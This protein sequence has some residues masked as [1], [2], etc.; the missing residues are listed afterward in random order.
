MIEL[1]G[2]A[3]HMAAH[4]VICHPTQAN[5][6]HPELYNVHCCPKMGWVST[7][8]V[9]TVAEKEDYFIPDTYLSTFHPASHM[10]ARWMHWATRW[11][12]SAALIV[13]S[14]SA[15][16]QVVSAHI[17]QISPDNVHPVFLYLIRPGFLLWSVVSSHCIAL[18]R[19][20]GVLY[21]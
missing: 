10:I 11:R 12:H 5:T 8:L 3:C 6:P 4:N 7:P 17:L 19:Y 13:A 16:S 21:S 14:S 18:A 20:S 1:Q 15:S 9:R 2:V